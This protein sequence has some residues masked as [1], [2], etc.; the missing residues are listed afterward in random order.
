LPN[1]PNKKNIGLNALLQVYLNLG[2]HIFLVG[3]MTTK[4][5]YFAFERLLLRMGRKFISRRISGW[6]MLPS[7][8][9]AL[10]GTI[11]FAT[12]DV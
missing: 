10:R 4:N 5:I 7:E 3:L 1:F 9:N 11:L 2:I 6:E 8:N 12:E